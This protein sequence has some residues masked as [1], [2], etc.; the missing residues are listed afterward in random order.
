MKWGFILLKILALLLIQFYIA[1][2]INLSDGFSA[3]LLKRS[4]LSPQSS[5]NSKPKDLIRSFTVTARNIDM[6]KVKASQGS[7]EAFYLFNIK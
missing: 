6:D 1:T 5:F 3:N 7:T 4:V 2:S